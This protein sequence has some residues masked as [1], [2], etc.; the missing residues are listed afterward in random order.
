[1][2]KLFFEDQTIETNPEESVLDALT[3][4]GNVIPF[5]CSPKRP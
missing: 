2:A 4:A 1:M 5:G 3:R